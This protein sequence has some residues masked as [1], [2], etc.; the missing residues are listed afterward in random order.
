[1]IRKERLGPRGHAPWSASG[2]RNPGYKEEFPQKNMTSPYPVRGRKW[3]CSGI[4]SFV[5][6]MCLGKESFTFV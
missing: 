1:V 5:K 2:R 4:I 3:G 6:V